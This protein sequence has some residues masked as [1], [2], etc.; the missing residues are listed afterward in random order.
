VFYFH[1]IDVMGLPFFN[2]I[3]RCVF[4][5]R[6]KQYEVLDPGGGFLCFQF[7]LLL[8]G[9][10]CTSCYQCLLPLKTWRGI[11]TLHQTPHVVYA[12]SHSFRHNQFTRNSFSFKINL[13]EVN[14]FELSGGIDG[15]S[16]FRDIN[17]L[18]VPFFFVIVS[19][20]FTSR[21]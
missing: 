7:R 11:R 15:C 3:W 1:V 21:I 4:V 6:V 8:L 9:C 20:F 17:Y 12:V 10:Q 2:I 16:K 19:T 5:V 13:F 14:R 18:S